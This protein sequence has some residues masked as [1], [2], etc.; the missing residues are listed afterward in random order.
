VELSGGMSLVKRL[1]SMTITLNFDTIGPGMQVL[2][3]LFVLDMN[4]A[5]RRVYIDKGNFQDTRSILM[6]D[7]ALLL[8]SHDL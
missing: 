8:W 7:G 6:S 2:P 5:G 4:E 3:A 1:R